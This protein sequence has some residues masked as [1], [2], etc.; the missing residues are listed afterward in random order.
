MLNKLAIANFFIGMLAFY[1]L[2]TQS[3]EIQELADRFSLD[4]PIFGLKVP[5]GYIAPPF[6]M[7]II[8]RIVK[9]HDRISDVFRIREF[10]DYEYVLNPMRNAVKSDVDKKTI[11]SNRN[12]LMSRIFY[13]YVSSRDENPLVDKHLIEMVLDQ[14]TWYWMIIESSFITICIFILLI[15]FN[16][17]EHALTIVYLSLGLIVFAKVL[18]K[19]CS[20]YTI[21]E[22]DI[23]LNSAPRKREIRKQFDELQH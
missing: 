2:T 15:Y 23:I 3:N 18:Q 1:F 6:I 22:V 20:K 14:L 21:R 13:S 17:F 11:L 9:L 7:A 8:F 4:I 16:K 10:Y 5:I 19:S 12:R